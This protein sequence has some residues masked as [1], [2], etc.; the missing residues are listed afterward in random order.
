MDEKIDSIN[1]FTEIMWW[2]ICRHTNRNTHD[3][4]EEKIWNTRRQNNWRNRATLVAVAAARVT[5]EGRATP[6]T[7]RPTTRARWCRRY[8][9]H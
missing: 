3:S 1:E 8:L 4:I 5:D 6:N 7:G 2:N 9:S